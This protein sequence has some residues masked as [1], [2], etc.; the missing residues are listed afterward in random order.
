MFEQ[1]NIPS[2]QYQRDSQ[3]SG[4]ARQANQ[5]S[6]ATNQELLLDL[7]QANNKLKHK[8]LQARLVAHAR[9]GAYK[10]RLDVP[11]MCRFKSHK[12]SMFD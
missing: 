4:Q 8:P 2:T 11:G 5:P 3:A 1:G 7:H 12:P 6:Q 9:L 10:L